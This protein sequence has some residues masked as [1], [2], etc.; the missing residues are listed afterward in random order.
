VSRTGCCKITG[1]V[2]VR[3]EGDAKSAETRLLAVTVLIAS[4]PLLLVLLELRFAEEE[5]VGVV[6]VV[7]IVVDCLG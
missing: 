7:A 4:L 3:S 2:G 5:E 6:W 1:L